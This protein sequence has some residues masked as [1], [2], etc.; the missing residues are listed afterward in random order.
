M[1]EGTFERGKI[2]GK[3]KYTGKNGDI[4][5]GDFRNSFL[6]GMGRIHTAEG[7][8]F[9]GFWVDG[10]LERKGRYQAP[11]K[12]QYVGD[13][14][15]GRFHG[16]GVFTFS[17]DDRNE[18]FYKLGY[19]D[20]KSEMFFGEAKLR[21]DNATG[22]QVLDHNSEYHGHWHLGKTV[23][24]GMLIDVSSGSHKNFFSTNDRNMYFPE[25]D[26]IQRRAE[27]VERKWR[28]KYI[29]RRSQEHE[30][31]R[32]VARYNRSNYLKVRTV[33]RNDTENYD[34]S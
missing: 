20:G 15:H 14:R 26:K 30:Q 10:R 32:R 6:N 9:E 1:F 19:R 27:K 31:R 17:N 3:G 25:L 13:F 24:R 5:G 28:R 7:K 34:V 2:V 16:R 4:V 8:E 33:K 23:T 11:N 21:L 29:R 18:G 12:S 22:K